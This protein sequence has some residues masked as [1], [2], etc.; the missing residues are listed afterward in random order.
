MKLSLS[1]ALLPL[2]ACSRPADDRAPM[3]TSS[4][5]ETPALLTEAPRLEAPTRDARTVAAPAP[6]PV[7]VTPPPRVHAEIAGLLRLRADA[8]RLA[9][10]GPDSRDAALKAY[11]AAEVEG[12]TLLDRAARRHD[13]DDT[14]FFV[15]QYRQ[16]L[17]ESDRLATEV[18]D[19][20][21]R[22]STPWTDMLASDRRKEWQDFGLES[23]RADADAIVIQG[24]REGAAENGLVAFPPTG[25][26]RDF[27]LE[28]EFTLEGSIDV[29]FRLG[30]R[31]DGTVESYHLATTGD[32]DPLV[33]GRT[34][35]LRASCV[36]GRL[37]GELSPSDAILPTVDSTWVNS[38]KGSIGFM[39][40]EEA[41]LVITKLRVRR[42]R[43][44]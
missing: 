31:V 17:E 24:P 11:A 33:S 1:V 36:G 39:I 43:D 12:E 25:G 29:L 44:A 40:R 14:K 3:T 7:E 42:L 15:G 9:S 16:I 34:Y 32:V 6:E 18:F 27:E 8:A 28:M 2:L 21:R 19:A 41:K 35:T 5:P 26:Y 38:R 22:E 30:R 20:R 23:F 13:Q 4:I 10:A 37:E